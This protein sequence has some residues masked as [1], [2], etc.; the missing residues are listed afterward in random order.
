VV[1]YQIVREPRRLSIRLV[2]RADASSEP[3][4]RVRERIQAALEDAGAI[5]PPIEVEVA[6]IE[7][8][9]GSAKLKLIKSVGGTR[10]VPSPYTIRS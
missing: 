6:A 4:G 3:P 8:E 2:L 1:Q 5:P 7:R 10:R 9:P